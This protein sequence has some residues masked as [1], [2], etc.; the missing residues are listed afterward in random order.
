MKTVKVLVFHPELCD[1]D[2]AC[3]RACSMVQY[4]KTDEGGEKS[5]LRIVKGKDGKFEC[6]VCNHCGLCI[7]LC[8]VMALKRLKSGVVALNKG[9]C[10]GCQ[11]CVAFCPTGVMRKAPG[12]IVPFK[13]I[14]CG[15]CVEAC[16]NK[17][18]E[19]VEM[20]IKDIEREVYARHGRVCP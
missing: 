2:R 11:S 15:K 19:L 20:N 18:L 13:C 4:F 10:V 17:A 16:P 5:A 9:V 12:Y 6:T 1:G 7:D 8:P 14:S 3:E